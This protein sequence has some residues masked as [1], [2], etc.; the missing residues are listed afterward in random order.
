MHVGGQFWGLREFPV[1]GRLVTGAAASRVSGATL[2]QAR[3]LSS[4]TFRGPLNYLSLTSQRLSPHPG[5]DW[6][7]TSLPA[8]GDS[9]SVPHGPLGQQILGLCL[10]APDTCPRPLTGS[11]RISQT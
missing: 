5:V 11:A 6:A 9:V 2:L 10:G 4:R 1:L 3:Y 8:D 7:I